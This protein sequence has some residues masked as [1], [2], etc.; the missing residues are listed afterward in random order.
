MTTPVPIVGLTEQ[1]QQRRLHYV[2]PADDSTYTNA[3]EAWRQRPNDDDC[4]TLII[5]SAHPS[6]E[7]IVRAPGHAK[8]ALLR[9]IELVIAH[10]QH[11]VQTLCL[12]VPL[13]AL[14]CFGEGEKA[15]ENPILLREQ[16][17]RKVQL[18]GTSDMRSQVALQYVLQAVLGCAHLQLFKVHLAG[19]TPQFP[20][21]VMQSCCRAHL[22]EQHTPELRQS[23][24]TENIV[25]EKVLSEHTQR[26]KDSLELYGMCG[27]TWS[28]QH[29]DEQLA[30]N[31]IVKIT[32]A[33]AA[34]STPAASM[35]KLSF[36]FHGEFSSQIL[37]MCPLLFP[38]VKEIHIH[39]CAPA[40]TPL[41]DANFL[42]ALTTA[43]RWSSHLRQVQIYPSEG[44]ASVVP[45][46]VP[47]GKQQSHSRREQLI[48]TV[49]LRHVDD[50]VAWRSMAMATLAGAVSHVALR[51]PPGA[52][53]DDACATAPVVAV[54]GTF[55]FSLL[56]DT[57]TFMTTLFGGQDA[58]RHCTTLNW[59][60]YVT[61]ATAPLLACA[62][63]SVATVWR[64]LHEY[65][66]AAHPPPPT[67]LA[68]PPLD[69]NPNTE[70]P[71]SLLRTLFYD[72]PTTTAVALG[73]GCRPVDMSDCEVPLR[74]HAA[75]AVLGAALNFREER[76]H[77]HTGKLRRW[78]DDVQRGAVPNAPREAALYGQ[79]EG[80]YY[81][82]GDGATNYVV[83]HSNVEKLCF[84]QCDFC[85]CTEQRW[86]ALLHACAIALGSSVR[87]IEFWMPHVLSDLSIIL[88]PFITLRK[89][90]FPQ[91]AAAL[92]HVP[93]IFLC[94]VTNT[95]AAAA[96]AALPVLD[97]VALLC[98][99]TSSAAVVD[100]LRMDH[101][102]NAIALC[103]CVA[104]HTTLVFHQPHDDTTPIPT[105]TT[106]TQLLP[107]GR[108]ITTTIVSVVGKE[109]KLSWAIDLP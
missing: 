24:V 50:V 91:L 32:N 90:H 48:V 77:E 8:R 54:E 56:T 79:V 66:L 99:Q 33:A 67:L 28:L 76:H 83:R 51:L 107:R 60:P 23:L 63:E 44:S 7:S 69:W 68:M 21:P 47:K 108:D 84:S 81:R 19:L 26:F 101:W 88:R 78:F 80:A 34:S 75:A 61:N 98:E 71:W 5:S 93:D 70:Q 64:Q 59:R 58:A 15:S 100:M 103:Q 17:P 95:T 55:R 106:L 96:A 9:L 89:T 86:V 85:A 45:L 57:A 35:K 102:R 38:Q 94:P 39:L 2:I 14:L 72:S 46:P 13:D 3:Y 6:A 29:S 12:E 43:H 11:G 40:S 49:K 92:F 105:W 27:L 53:L 30:T 4:E 109:A 65:L 97:N 31:E 73:F 25:G 16:D 37:F 10:V 1:Q 36:V 52:V 87:S 82:S 18:W 62:P 104:K 20:F 41:L 74:Y 22:R 42:V